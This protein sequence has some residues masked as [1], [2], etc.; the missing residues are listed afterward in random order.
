MAEELKDLID[1]INEEGVK[2]AEDKAGKIALEAKQQAQAIL[3]K[4]RLDA[5]RMVS[6]AHGRIAR[7]EASSK[8]SLSQAA[9]DMLLSLRKEINAMLDRIITS[10]IHKAISPEELSSIIHGLIKEHDKDKA[11][12][13]ISMKKDDLEKIEKALLASL[14]EEVKKGVTLR[15]SGEI[16]GGF[17]ISYDSGKSYYDF[18][19]KALAEYISVYLKPKIGEMLKEL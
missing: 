1:K 18:T 13:V 3:E 4:A 7:E 19:D 6:D 11:D 2:A 12:I 14:K 5:E 15:S 10:H 16:R 9:R 17:T 8:E